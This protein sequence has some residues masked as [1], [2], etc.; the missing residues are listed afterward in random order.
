MLHVLFDRRGRRDGQLVGRSPYLQ[1]VHA[2]ASDALFG[3]IAAVRIRQATL[4]SLGGLVE[5][6]D[7]STQTRGADAACRP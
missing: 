5:A 4:N 2:P 6:A 1:A 7:R 3:A